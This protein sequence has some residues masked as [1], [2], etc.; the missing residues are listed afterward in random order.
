VFLFKHII[1]KFIGNY[2]L[3]PVCPE[4]DLRK[5]TYVSDARHSEESATPFLG[6]GKGWK[7]EGREKRERRI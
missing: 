5:C 2:L 6:R 4:L 7:G 3:V 1:F